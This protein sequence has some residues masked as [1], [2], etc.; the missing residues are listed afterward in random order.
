MHVYLYLVI[1]ISAV[2]YTSVEINKRLHTYLKKILELIYEVINKVQN[3]EFLFI[4]QSNESKFF[5]EVSSL[6]YFFKMKH[7]IL[8][9]Y[10]L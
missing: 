9:M 2:R 3:I 10:C 7:N 1:V 6:L 8:T 4:L 5:Y